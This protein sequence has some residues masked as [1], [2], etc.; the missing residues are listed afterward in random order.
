M[1]QD[2]ELPIEDEIRIR[3]MFAK[4]VHLLDTGDARGWGNLFTADGSWT[5]VNSPS[6]QLGGS[7]LP[8]ETVEG[9]ENLVQMALDVVKSRFNGLVRHQMTDVYVEPG[10]DPDTARGLS[11]ALI[12]DWNDGPG[13]V[14]MVGDYKLEFRRTPDGWRIRSIE[15][16]LVPS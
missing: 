10:D 7:G 14:S 6:R 4:Y 15:C 3:S 11:R 2:K 9:R 12:T 5:R 1:A 13:K 16:K 8:A